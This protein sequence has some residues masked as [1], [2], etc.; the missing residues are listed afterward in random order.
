MQPPLAGYRVLDVTIFQ[1]GPWATCMLA[2]MGADVIHIEHPELGDP[3]R[4]TSM[5]S[6]VPTVNPY[7]ETMNRG[8]RSMT[9][10]LQ[11][12]EGQD[13]FYRM[14]GKSDI[15]VQNYRHG[16]VQKMK[17]D[18]DTVARFNP[19]IIYCS[20]TGFGSEGPDARDGVYDLLGQARS[21]FL[22]M[23]ALPNGEVR[24]QV[25]GGIGDQMGAT[26]ASQAILWAVIARERYGVGQHVE[27]SQLGAL[28]VL[29][30]MGINT[31]LHHQEMKPP[32]DRTKV[33]NPLVNVYMGS[34]GKWLALSCV[35]YDRYW[36]IV[37]SVL[38]LGDVKDDPRFATREAGTVNS[39]ALIQLLDRRFA[40]KPCAEWVS[41]L[42]QAGAICTAVLQYD[43][44]E[45]DPQV[46]ANGYLVDV[47]HATHGDL[48][49]VGIP[50]RLSATPGRVTAAA[51]EF[52]QHTAEVLLEHGY[53]WDEVAHFE[54]VGA[55]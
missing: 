45:R 7:F 1:N 18:Y 2:D 44:L 42:K 29:Q 12:E 32:A 50:A 5:H 11:S 43:D 26:Y 10:N 40:D 20:I 21:G 15:V 54:E 23:L 51:P 49:Q 55:I 34:D 37:C 9:L 25:E 31:Y 14:A 30:A 22:R 39:G 35:Q 13:I 19:K 46:V 24:Y 53:S 47:P 16:V 4:G 38:G 8:K 48:R 27:V 52:G 28:M 3:G 36:P 17:V 33:G 6:E 41:G